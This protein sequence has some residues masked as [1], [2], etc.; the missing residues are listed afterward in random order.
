[1]D[2]PAGDGPRVP[3][4]RHRA[5]VALMAGVLVALTDAHAVLVA[6]L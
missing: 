4:R 3:D 1:M 2:A 6:A 5:A